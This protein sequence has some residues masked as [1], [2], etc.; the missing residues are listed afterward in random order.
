[1]RCR[2]Y[3]RDDVD[4]AEEL[5]RELVMLPETWRQGTGQKV[6]RWGGHGSDTFNYFCHQLESGRN[7]TVLNTEETERM[8]VA[9]VKRIRD[10]KNLNYI[11]KIKQCKTGWALQR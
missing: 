9:I 6:R 1:M 8:Q 5:A 7:N 11:I 4:G 10:S 2:V 3:W